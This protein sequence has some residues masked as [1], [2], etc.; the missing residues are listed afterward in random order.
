MRPRLSAVSASAGCAL[1]PEVTTAGSA[2]EKAGHSL[3][4][5]A[6]EESGRPV[7]LV[8]SDAGETS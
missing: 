1:L 3:P 6:V 2:K 5:H 8:L 7:L 4:L